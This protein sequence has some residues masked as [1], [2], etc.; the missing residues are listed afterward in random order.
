MIKVIRNQDARQIR[1]PRLLDLC[2]AILSFATQSFIL[3]PAQSQ[4]G[5]SENEVE[6][7]IA[8]SVTVI[9]TL[10]FSG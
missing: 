10:P 6:D 3:G 5:T 4:L 1:D 7:V 8:M 9:G 2:L